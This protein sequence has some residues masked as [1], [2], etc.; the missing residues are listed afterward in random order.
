MV[1]PEYPNLVDAGV[2]NG[3]AGARGAG[4]AMWLAWLMVIGVVSGSL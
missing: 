1:D 3:G 4:V 2:W